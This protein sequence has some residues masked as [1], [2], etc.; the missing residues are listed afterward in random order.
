M[1]SLQGG[2][3]VAALLIVL[4]HAS[5]AIFAN[6]KYW[7][8]DPF[9]G[10]FSFGDSGV[11]FFFV[12]SGFIIYHAHERDLGR[13]ERLQAY[14][15]KRFRRIYPIYWLIVI[16][17]LP[18]YLSVHS[19]GLGYETQ[20]EV[21]LSSLLLVHL[22][23]LHSV[24][25]VG[26]TLFH[27][28][29]FYA[30]F[31]VAI[32]RVRVGFVLLGIWFAASTQA[33]NPAFGLPLIGFYFSYLHL[34]FG[35][36]LVARRLFGTVVIPLPHLV[37]LLGGAVI[38]AMAADED[39]GNMLSEMWR[40]LAYGV[41]CTFALL[42]IVELERQG[43]LTTPR[44]LVLLG[45]ASYSI[46][47]VHFLALSLLAKLAWASGAAQLPDALS[48][49]LLVAG[50]TGSGVLLHLW[51]ERPLLARLGQKPVTRQVR[52]A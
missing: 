31:A 13:P 32:W 47:L 30:F 16:L 18:I 4:F 10:V 36:G 8:H 42:G 27:E 14:L 43:R 25:W 29:L 50:A 19:F 44:P 45:D 3:G 9:A 22:Q 26:W 34:L 20:P 17:V 7:H 33:A 12:L 6:A 41:G 1:S 5:R 23:S 35:L 2:R 38:L 15:W 28:V 46:Y 21:I 11:T 39:Y 49:L 40:T 51:V 24:L 37:T 52:T 48:Y